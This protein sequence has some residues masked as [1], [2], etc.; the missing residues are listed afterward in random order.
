MPQN[1]EKTVAAN[2]NSAALLDTRKPAENF[3]IDIN[4]F[5]H[6]IEKSTTLKTMTPKK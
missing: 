2:K 3:M 6:Q 5:D 1:L 4:D